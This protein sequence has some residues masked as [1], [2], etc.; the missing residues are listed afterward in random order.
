V[1]FLFFSCFLQLLWMVRVEF[2]CSL[3]DVRRRTAAAVFLK[4]TTV[5]R[6]ELFAVSARRM[7]TRAATDK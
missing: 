6:T 5:G 4:G 2:L 3:R 1:I 7:L